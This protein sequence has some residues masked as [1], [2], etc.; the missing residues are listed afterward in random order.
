MRSAL[1]ERRREVYRMRYRFGVDESEVVSRL[2]NQ[3]D[4]TEAT[5]QH[6]LNT[7]DEWLSELDIPLTNEYAQLRNLRD[8]QQELEQLAIRAQQ[9]GDPAETRRIRQLLIE[10]LLI[11]YE[12]SRELNQTE[13][14]YSSG[15]KIGEMDHQTEVAIGM[16]TGHDY[17]K[18]DEELSE[19]L[20][21]DE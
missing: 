18:E 4:V 2:V 3:Y 1:R 7:M 10:L 20:G 16:F 15:N 11:E 12:K 5:I 17:L 8:Q 21:T 13:G 19:V 9:E 6:D 14:P